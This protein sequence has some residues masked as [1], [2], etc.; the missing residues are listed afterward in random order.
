MGGG[1]QITNGRI[2]KSRLRDIFSFR[3]QNNRID[4]EKMYLKHNK[5]D[6]FLFKMLSLEIQAL[7]VVV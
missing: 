3:D 2:P 4:I 5:N 7:L 1:A 6:F